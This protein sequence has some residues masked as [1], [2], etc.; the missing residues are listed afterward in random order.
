MRIFGVHLTVT[1][2]IGMLIIVVCV[3]GAVLAPW[4]APHDPNE[5]IIQMRLATP[6]TGD[7]LLG[8]DHVGRDV[9]SRLLYA[10]RVSLGVALPSMVIAVVVGV[11]VGAL[12]GYYG[13]WIDR[14]LS[15]HTGCRIRWL[16]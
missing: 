13:G 4:I 12:S 16:P 3:G 11:V 2:I 14:A 8:G 9:L 10:G 7:Y 1:A 5:Q 6:G 15:H